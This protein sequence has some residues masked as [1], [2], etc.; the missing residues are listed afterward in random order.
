MWVEGRLAAEQPDEG[1][2]NGQYF[3]LQGE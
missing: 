1:T 3:R 2:T